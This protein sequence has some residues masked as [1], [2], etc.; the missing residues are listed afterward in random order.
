MHPY[1]CA[2]KRARV[3]EHKMKPEEA[4]TDIEES[5]FTRVNQTIRAKEPPVQE[6]PV[7]QPPKKD[8]KPEELP[9][10]HPSL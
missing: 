4:V 6:T 10:L 9:L 7:E 8:P 5:P 3:G 2:G 1:I